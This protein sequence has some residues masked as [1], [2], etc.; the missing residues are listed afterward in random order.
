MYTTTKETHAAVVFLLGEHAYKLKKPVDLGFL[1]FSTLRAR[2]WACEQEVE[3]NRRLC[4][5]VYEGVADVVGPGGEVCE[6]LVVM[7][8]MPEERRLATLVKAGKPVDEHLRAVARRLAALHAGARHGP[9]IDREGGLDALRARW[10]ASFEQVR[11]LPGRTV[12]PAVLDETE[13]LA[14]RFLDGRR[15][16]FDARVAGRRVVDGHGDLLAED[17]FCLDD[18]PRILDCLE[19]DERLRFLD[20][21]DDAAFLAMDLERLGAPRQAERFLRWYVEFS[22]DPAPPALWHHYVAYRAFVRAKVACLRQWQGETDA[23]WE[24]RRLSELALRHLR[25]G[26]VTL[27]LVGGSPGSG[28]STLAGGL[29]DRLGHTLLRSDRVR[30]ELAGLDPTRAASAPYRQGIYDPAHTAR[31][32]AELLVRAERLL[33]QGEPVI[34]DASWGDQRHR[35]VAA[36]VAARTSS[37]LVALRCTVMPQV[38]AERLVTRE[39]ELSDADEEIRRKMAADAPD[40]PDAVEID[41]GVEPA[42]A[43]ERALAAVRPDGRERSWRFQRSRIEAG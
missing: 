12:D 37:D 21:L 25:A 5:D 20:G 11:G 19:F 13:R 35:A 26:A 23:G 24:A 14:T 2:R 33:G 10:N 41:T 36:E 18:G 29:A 6:H 30:K 32:Y 39:P 15:A 17:V 28:K 4:D 43:L 3:L 8:R 27:V 7:R 38:A 34:I 42:Q 31:T 16:L 22:G 9:Q 40:W 1:D